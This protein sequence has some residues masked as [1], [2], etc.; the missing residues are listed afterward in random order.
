M[1]FNDSISAFQ[2]VWCQFESGY[3]LQIN[4]TSKGKIAMETEN[5]QMNEGIAIHSIYAKGKQYREDLPNGVEY[6]HAK[7]YTVAMIYYPDGEKRV[8]VAKRNPI[9]RPSRVKG[10]MIAFTRALSK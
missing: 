7:N 10:E 6:F 9:D 5:L 1:V 4:L 2:A 8:G 3:P